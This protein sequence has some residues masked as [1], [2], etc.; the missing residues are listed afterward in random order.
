M[1]LTIRTIL[2][3]LNSIKLVALERGNRGLL[4][5]II[6]ELDDLKLQRYIRFKI[7]LLKSKKGDMRKFDGRDS[8]NWILQ[9]E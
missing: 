2:H 4:Q 1:I 7:E 9:M 8:V 5:I 3:N 6:S